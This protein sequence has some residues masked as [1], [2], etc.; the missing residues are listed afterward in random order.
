M[1][2]VSPKPVHSTKG[3]HDAVGCTQLAPDG[4]G[5]PAY[6]VWGSA[7]CAHVVGVCALEHRL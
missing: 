2:G 3:G 5:H 6:Q 1:E 4:R 7:L